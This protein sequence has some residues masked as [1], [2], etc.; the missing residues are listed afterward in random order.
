MKTKKLKVDIFVKNNHSVYPMV[1]C[2][3]GRSGTSLLQ[4]MLA[5]HSDIAMPPETHFL[6][7]YV[8]NNRAK[9]KLSSQGPE[10]FEKILE[11]DKD[12]S[13]IDINAAILLEPYKIGDEE[14]SLE[15]VFK[16]M[17]SIFMKEHKRQFLGEKDPNLIE[18]L[19]ELSKIF[20]TSRAI[21]LIRDPRDVLVSRMKADWS[22]G[23]HFWI[24][25]L[26]YRAQLAKGRKTGERALGM[27]YAEIRYED[28][29]SE[30]ANTLNK[31]C[32][33]LDIPYENA[34]LNFNKAASELV[35]KEEM[36]W[37]KET[38]G[39]LLTKNT[40]KWKTELTD[41][42]ICMTE[43]LCEKAFDDLNY[44]KSNLYE[45][46]ALTQKIKLR[47]WRMV[48]IGFDLLYLLRQKSRARR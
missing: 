13:R 39:P 29:I 48:G 15:A 31:I 5:A 20:P 42:Q 43:T 24:H 7:N 11:M 45:A 3:V 8:L 34:M 22:R 37:K 33:H 17:S 40:G 32:E 16:R 1:V 6:R 26:T 25:I 44:E 47:L 41:W 18:M 4:S 21:H 46:L 14:F 9:M 23:R 27:R 30:P 10:I 2:G 28:L 19:P 35:S 36:Q 12:F 38:L